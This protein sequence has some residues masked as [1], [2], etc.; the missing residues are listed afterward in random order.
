MDFYDAQS[1]GAGAWS[2]HS[3]GASQA[4]ATSHGAAS[5]HAA[6]A[7]FAP[8]APGA[9]DFLDDALAVV[10]LPGNEPARPVE[11]SSEYGASN[12][13]NTV[14]AGNVAANNMDKYLSRM[15]RVRT[16]LTEEELCTPAFWRGWAEWLFGGYMKVGGGGA[17]G[18]GQIGGTLKPAT[19]QEYLEKELNKAEKLYNVNKKHDLFFKEGRENPKEWWK[20][21]LRA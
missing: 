3:A 16:S 10:A 6:A 5:F 4:A 1:F 18:A 14:R 21:L 20:T 2:A 15:G 12:S 8:L 9:S 7:S 17:G 11:A 13:G 19:I